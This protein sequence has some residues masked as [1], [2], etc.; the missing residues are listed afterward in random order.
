MQE[1]VTEGFPDSDWGVDVTQTAGRE[2]GREA[3]PFSFAS[4]DFSQEDAVG[5]T[6]TGREKAIQELVGGA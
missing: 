2:G 5:V 4:L 6:M 3:F 1:L